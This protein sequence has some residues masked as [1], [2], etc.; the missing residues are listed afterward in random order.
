[1]R[2]AQPRPGLAT[3]LAAV[4]VGIGLAGLLLA[5]V[6]EVATPLWAILI[7]CAITAELIAA[8][9]TA[10]LRISAA[11]VATMLAVGFLGPAAAF[12]LPAATYAAVWVVER[13]RWQALL[14]N[15]AGSATP[16]MAVAATLGVLDPEHGGLELAALLMAA[17]AVTMA[18]NV[19]IVPPLMALL[20]GASVLD[21]LRTV[22]GILPAVALNAALVGVIAE[23]Y[24]EAGLTAL[25]FVLLNAIAFTYMARLV[26]VARERTRQYAN[27]SWGVLSGLVR[28][29]DERD[30]RAA[31][32]CAAV[33]AFSRDLAVQLGMSKRDQELAH[34]AGLLHDIGKFALSDRVMERGGKLLDSDW[35]GI[36]RHPDIGAELLRDIGVYGPVAEI[37]RAHH[38]RVDGRGY[39]RGL[40]GDE[41]P[42][43]ARV[44]A[45][46]EVYDTLTAPDTYRTPMTSFEALNELRRVAGKQLD[47]RYVEALAK[48]LAGRGVD[49][50]HADE[51]DF[52]R[53]LDIE[54]RVNEAVAP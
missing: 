24:A 36:R 2:T 25:V 3:A 40:S 54:R 26:V 44:V 11:F 43:I 33:A 27:L 31:R 51:A 47:A 12:A 14:I 38:E 32:H 7:A 48:M 53:E 22:R 39:P 13:Y 5:D 8:R 28:T 49:Y 52:D 6:G 18:L 15:I 21:Y 45:V 50:R 46:A 23:I 19:L 20:D 9:Y 29:L 37:V 4:I 34:T 30:S 35:R 16:A 41:I 42:P 10:Q 17:T 1:M